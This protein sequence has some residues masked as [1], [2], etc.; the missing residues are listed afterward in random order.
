MPLLQKV[1]K[2][3]CTF[4]D[5]ST[6]DVDAIILCTGYLHHFPFMA[7]ELK[8]R[9]TNRLAIANLYKGVVWVDS[10]KLFYLGM[11]NQWFSFPIFNAQA[12][13]VR[14]IIMGRIDVPGR[15][16]RVADVEDR[17]VR[18]DAGK[19]KYDQCRY[20]NA[21]IKELAADTDC[22]SFDVDA[23]KETFFQVTKHKQED[24][25]TFRN[26]CFKSL[27][28]GTMAPKHTPWKDDFDDSL[29]SYL[30]D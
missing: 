25:M 20:Q 29:E 3:T 1:E 15:D 14:D 6:A 17:I 18:E 10:P 26:K 21:Y 7:N 28:T 16:A 2:N 23:A 11:Q 30:R 9:A 19:D 12:W 8:L 27:V 4:E 13:Y 5:G 24:I 22:P